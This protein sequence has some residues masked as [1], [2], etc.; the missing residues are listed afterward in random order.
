MDSPGA[1][2]YD[3]FSTK[4]LKIFH[5]RLNILVKHEKSQISLRFR[6]DCLKYMLIH[7]LSF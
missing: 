5:N 4:A 3:N 2:H 6:V 1:S 7:L